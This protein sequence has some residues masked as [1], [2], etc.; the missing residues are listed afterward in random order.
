M[1]A[2]CLDQLYF[3]VLIM[4][5]E[6]YKLWISHFAIFCSLLLL[7]SPQVTD[8]FWTIPLVCQHSVGFLY[9]SD[10]GILK[11][12]NCSMSA[13]YKLCIITKYFNSISWIL[14]GGD[15]TVRAFS[16]LLVPEFIITALHTAEHK[17]IA[18]C[19]SCLL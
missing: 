19:R 3:S 17:K 13:W 18:L 2:K 8:I 11:P 1:H 10:D 9:L 4:F 14:W 7:N 12:G 6:E 16:C 5:D 15:R